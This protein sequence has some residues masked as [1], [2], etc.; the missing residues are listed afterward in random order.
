MGGRGAPVVVVGA[1]IVGLAAARELAERGHRVLVLEAEDRIAAHQSGHN[2][3]VVHSGLYYRPGSA[4][5]R[6]CVSGR[7][8]LE[9]F[10]AEEGVAHRRTGKLVLATEAGE[11]PG[12]DELERR[13]RANGLVGLERLDAGALRERFPE[14]GGAAG[15]W[16]PQTGVVDFPGVA[17]ALARRLEGAGGTVRTGSRV[18][19]LEAGGRAVG[20]LRLRLVGGEA[21]PARF[22]VNC[23]GLQADR[24]AR[25]AGARPDVRIV[26]FRGDYRELAPEARRLVPVPVYPVP[27]PRFPFLGVHLTPTLD[28]R[29]EVGPTALLAP[30]RRAY[31]R[32]DPLGVGWLGHP[33]PGS[34]GRTGREPGER[35]GSPVRDLVE[36][37]AYPGFWRLAR[38]HWRA[39]TAELARAVSEGRF[40]RDV[41]RLVPGVEAAHL[42]PGGRGL[43]AQALDR[44]G[45]LV[46][47]F[48]I[49]H[50]EGAVHVLNAPS[51]A[52][53][54][55]LAIGREI[56]DL[57]EERLG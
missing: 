20:D 30:H 33:K 5:A 7:E 44:D 53:T 41:Q 12:L 37:L 43:R 3:G 36:T 10:C 9:R 46:D 2:S 8:A 15:L 11:L 52:A 35:R 39:G 28:G 34:G 49:V 48:R 17:R 51:P 21:V 19:A 27:D 45:R 42:R 26:P 16:V 55:A 6:L 22:L 4:K 25:L 14:A 18:V 47:D 57:V 56:A 29:V 54:A 1:G 38:R 50:G 13:G 24:V 23:A 40:L 31:R 32:G